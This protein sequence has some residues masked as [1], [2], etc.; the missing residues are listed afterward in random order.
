[1]MNNQIKVTKKHGEILYLLYR[2]RFLTRIQ[3]QDLLGHHE[4]S[5]LNR[6]LAELKGYQFI[7]KDYNEKEGKNRSPSIC[8][9]DKAG[10][11]YIAKKY[12][13]RNSYI[14][15]LRNEEGISLIT[16]NHSI[17]AADFYLILS[18]YANTMNHTLRYFTKADLAGMAIY[19]YSKPDAYVSYQTEKGKRRCFIEIDLETESIPTIRKKLINYDKFFI[20]DTWKSKDISDFP[21]IAFICLTKNRLEKLITISENIF[22]QRDITVKCTTFSEIKTAGINKPIWTT[23]FTKN[24]TFKLL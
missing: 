18:K 10:L 11:S 19:R 6:W 9:L 13:L 16:K 3:I 20:T 24:K 5:R 15:K 4:P 2:F 21:S 7:G 23:L 1:M 22:Q 8:F 12:N 17:A 14:Q